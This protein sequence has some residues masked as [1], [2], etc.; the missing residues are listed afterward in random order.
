MVRVSLFKTDEEDHEREAY[1]YFK[2][3]DIIRLN[4]YQDTD[5]DDDDDY[6]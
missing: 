1:A 6:L 2:I 4:P 5:D 3:H